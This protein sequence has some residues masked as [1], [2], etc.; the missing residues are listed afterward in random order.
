MA[1]CADVLKHTRNHY[2]THFNIYTCIFHI[3]L[4]KSCLNLYRSIRL[5]DLE[6]WIS[7]MLFGITNDFIITIKFD[8]YLNQWLCL[9]SSWN[10]FIK[11]ACADLQNIYIIPPC[12]IY[13][14]IFNLSLNVRWI[15]IFSKIAVFMMVSCT[16]CLTIFIISHCYLKRLGCL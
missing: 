14:V 2:P 8:E 4:Y 10:I 16:I 9:T 5:G 7:C 12:T 1:L 6:P 13:L 15:I 11:P 3:W